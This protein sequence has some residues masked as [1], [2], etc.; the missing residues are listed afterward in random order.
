VH[1]QH[2]AR[3]FSGHRHDE[4]LHPRL[5]GVRGQPVGGEI[6]EQAGGDQRQHDRWR[7]PASPCPAAAQQR[8][9]RSTDPGWAIPRSSCF[10]L[11]CNLWRTGIGRRQGHRQQV[12][13]SLRSPIVSRV[14]SSTSGRLRACCQ[15]PPIALYS[16]TRLCT[17]LPVVADQSLLLAEQRPL[18][19]EHA[20][21]AGH[22]LRDTGWWRYQANA[23]PP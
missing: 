6:P 23:A 3:H 21:E 18:R 2:L 5:R 19:I 7:R 22:T 8:R 11:W 10:P 15:P 20:L 9:L 14:A 16:V 12:R 13:Q 1:R 17:T 4:R